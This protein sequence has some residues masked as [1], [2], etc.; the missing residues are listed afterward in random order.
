MASAEIG[1][2]EQRRIYYDGQTCTSYNVA[3]KAYATIDAAATLTET[4]DLLQES[5]GLALPLA[6]LLRPDLAE[7][8]VAEARSVTYVGRENVG[9]ST[10]HKITVMTDDV[11]GEMWLEANEATPRPRM[12]RLHYFT[13]PNQPKYEA[14][15]DAWNAV[16]HFAEG[17]F[18]FTPPEGA[19]KVEAVRVD[20]PGP[21]S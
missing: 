2:G 20:E 3:K 7:A 4:I 21:D 14:V 17:Q 10:C 12:I 13:H 18:T 9:T 19:V 11:Q 1:G 15:I 5:Y 16:D 8:I 6:D